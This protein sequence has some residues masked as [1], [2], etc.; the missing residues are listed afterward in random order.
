[1]RWE[2]SGRWVEEKLMRRDDTIRLIASGALNVDYLHRV[3][4]IVTDGE[5]RVISVYREPGGSAANTAYA[6][7]K[8]G[9]MCA[10]V[11]CI[12]DDEDGKL[13]LSSFKEVGM[14]TQWV[15]AKAGART[16]RVIGFVDNS[17]KR[18][19]YVLAG[20]NELIGKDDFP[21]QI[22]QSVE[23]V[24]CTSLVGDAPMRHQ[25]G[26]V[27]GLPS[28]VKFSFAPGAIYASLGFDALKGFLERATITFLSRDELASLT[29]ESDMYESLRMLHSVG[30]SIVAVTMGSEGSILSYTKNAIA[31]HGI[32]PLNLRHQRVQEE[33]KHSLLYEEALKANV[34]DTT[35]AGDAFA[36]GMLL[37]LIRGL[38]LDVCHKLACC[39]ASICIEGF[40]ARAA[41]PSL[42][43]LIERYK[44]AYG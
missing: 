3:P 35:G 28:R 9:V 25:L 39:A 8:W 43:M 31:A 26:W 10:F 15:K 1:M 27:T 21:K 40:G 30:V 23:W 32:K 16:G 42:E 13:L 24:H 4:Q 36:A 19:L 29:G 44:E 14:H 6:L 22:P 37:G 11:G 38:P 41:I 33:N 5:T 7:S 20:A 17:G 18:A 34:V 2:G 12:G